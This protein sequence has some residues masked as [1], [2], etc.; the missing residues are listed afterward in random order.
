MSDHIRFVNVTKSFGGVQVLRDVNFGI[1]AGEVHALIGEN[2]AGKSTLMK[3]LAGYHQPTSGNVQIGGAPVAFHSSRDAEQQGVVLIHQEFNLADDLTVEQNL[4]LGREWGRPF[5][6]ER[7]MREHASSALALVGLRLDPRRRVRDLSVPQKQLVEIAKALSRSARVLVM[8]EPTAALT[9]SETDV[10]FRLIDDLRAGGVT[11]VY[12]SHKLDEVRRV[13]DRV[14]VLRDGVA[15]TTEAVETL[16]E[17]RMANLMVGRELSDMYPAR[18]TPTDTELLRVEG[19]SVPGWARDVTFSVRQGEV[20]GFAGL[21][22]AG[23]TEAFEGLFGLRRATLTRALRDG[24][25]V[26]LGSPQRAARH[27]MVYL[28]E[29][30]KGKGLHV[31]L[32][33]QPNLTL[34]TLERYARPLLDHRAE[35]AALKRAVEALGIRTGRLDVPAGALSGGNQQ[36]LALARILETQPDVIVLDEPT[37]GVDVGAKRDIYVLIHALAQAGKGIVVISSELPELLGLCHRVLVMR[38]G[39][40]TGSLS[41]EQLT[42]QEV[43]R[44]AT[45]LKGQA[46]EA[47]A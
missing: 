29:D 3:I 11:I 16:S 12:I 24:R 28:S 31:N 8:D 47:P 20:L 21:M 40:V 25:A 39:R 36:K 19:L 37:R 6:D 41:G 4:H 45:G 42:E 10:L 13:A 14:T 1:H 5:L 38:E 18:A 44:Y 34:M 30:R 9:P 43:I 32:P 33:L 17:H 2:G 15:V 26:K 7:G 27:G 23:R 46:E 22:G 35:R